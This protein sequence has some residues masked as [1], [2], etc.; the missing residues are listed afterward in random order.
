MK[1]LFWVLWAVVNVPIGLFL[2]IP[3]VGMMG[4]RETTLW[5]LLQG[6]VLAPFLITGLYTLLLQWIWWYLDLRKDPVWRLPLLTA[7]GVVAVPVL[8]VCMMMLN[9]YLNE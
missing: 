1:Y 5:Q 4:N 6:L 3:F 8:K 9:S 2:M 7:L